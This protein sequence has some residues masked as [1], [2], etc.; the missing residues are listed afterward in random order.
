MSDF[1]STFPFKGYNY[2]YALT[3]ILEIAS[4]EYGEVTAENFWKAWR[5]NG[6]D[7]SPK[8]EGYKTISPN[9]I[10]QIWESR[11]LEEKILKDFAKGRWDLKKELNPERKMVMNEGC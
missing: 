2:Y 9:Y 8:Q 5:L 6:H 3:R 7:F 10:Q 1:Y 4:E 11:E